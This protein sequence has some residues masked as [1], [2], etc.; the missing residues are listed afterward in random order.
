[1]A[2]KFLSEEYR[3]GNTSVKDDLE[4]KKINTSRREGREVRKGKR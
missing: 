3:L 4:N 2:W 1:M